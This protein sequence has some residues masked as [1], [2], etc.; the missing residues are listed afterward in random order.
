[1]SVIERLQFTDSII[2]AHGN[3]L[4]QLLLERTRNIHDGNKVLVYSLTSP[5]A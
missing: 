3:C 4:Y 1:M 2:K 5:L